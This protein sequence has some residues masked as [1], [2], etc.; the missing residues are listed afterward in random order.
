MNIAFFSTSNRTLPLLKTLHKVSNVKLCITKE[1]VR[2]G[3]KQTLVEN[4]IKIWARKNKVKCIQI[5]GSLSDVGSKNIDLGIVIDFGVIIPKNVIES[6]SGNLINI[7]FS[8]LPKYRGASPVQFA[9]LNGDSKTGVT[10]QYIHEK[11]DEG[12]ILRQIEY[13]MTNKETF[14]HLFLK[15]LDSVIEDIPTFI[16]DYGKNKITPLPQDELKATY[17]F[18][19]TNPK[20]T[21][22]SKE[23][24]FIDFTEKPALIERMSRA[25][26]PWPIVWTHLDHF[27]NLGYTLK[28]K[29][30]GPLKV[31][32]HEVGLLGGKKIEVVRIQPEG[33]SV[34]GWKSFANGYLSAE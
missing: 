21:T 24:A 29:E 6:F 20:I 15:L 14:G 17:T 26:S 2:V 16:N 7:H 32:L 5:K 3:R 8:L 19:K 25:F 10:Y 31:K 11:M 22:V 9:I 13:K 1:D 27:S 23:D 12:D 4:P 18:S 33:K 28:N 34:M 30:K